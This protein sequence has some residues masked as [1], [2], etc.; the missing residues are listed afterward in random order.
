MKGENR[1]NNTISETKRLMGYVERQGEILLV[2]AEFCANLHAPLITSTKFNIHKGDLFTKRWIAEN[3]FVPCKKNEATAA[4][5]VGQKNPN[6]FSWI[7][8]R[9]KTFWLKVNQNG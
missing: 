8:G 6:T 4:L 7:A 3:G 2:D 5:I 1:Y 9:C